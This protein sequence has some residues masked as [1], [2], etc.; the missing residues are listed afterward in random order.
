[1]ESKRKEKPT[2]YHGGSKLSF[3]S[4]LRIFATVVIVASHA[5][6][7]LPENPEIFSL[8]SYE[9]IFLEI[10]YNLTKWAVPVFFMVTGA[11]LLG[12]EKKIDIK[13][14][15]CKYAKRMTLALLVFGIPYAILMILFDT[16]TLSLSII[17][18]ANIRLINGD[19]F[20]H[21]WYL[22]TLIGIYLLLPIF[23]MFVEHSS[24]QTLKYVMVILF[25]YNFIFPFID[26]LMGSHIAFELP[27]TTYPISYMLMGYYLLHEKP[28]IAENRWVPVAGIV[29]S[30]L[31]VVLVG[32]TRGPLT[33]IMSYSS[34]IAFVFAVS[35]FSTF[36][37]IKKESTER[38][39][40]VDRLCFGAYLIHPLFIQFVYKFL[41]IVPT[42]NSLFPIW[43][44]VFATVFV[45]LSFFA[46]WVMSLVKPLKKYIL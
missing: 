46:S 8:K 34:P 4:Y 25:I 10:A 45:I 6:S 2:N 9:R 17:I 11:L 12:P 15:I 13:D 24:K 37:R 40:K 32:L 20:G 41:H 31:V 1:M 21:L 3:I 29:V 42:G 16:K 36:S 33:S 38:L 35:V 39:W 5:W 23:R 18:E 19:S 44:F 14:C 22:Y 30:S 27:I 43:S 28:C 26:A 7:T